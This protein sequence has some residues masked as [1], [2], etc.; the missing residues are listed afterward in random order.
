MQTDTPMGPAISQNAAKK[1]LLRAALLLV[2]LT[3]SHLSHAQVGMPWLTLDEG[4][5]AASTDQKILFVFV[6]AEWCAFCKRMK[7]EVF[8]NDAVL[9]LLRSR[10]V[11]V[12]IDV[13]SKSRVHFNGK[14]YSERSFAR[15]M[16][17]NATPT[18]IFA[19]QD[20]EI[21]GQ[22]SGFYDTDRFLLLLNY[23]DSDSFK[24]IS[25]DVFEKQRKSVSAARNDRPE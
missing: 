8:P 13:D 22:T 17:V 25:F 14:T 16:G 12:S 15:E 23:L 9:N 24:D 21:L 20:G 4:Q 7:R 6:E 19:N 10:F 1:S 18:I 3:G 2:L 11:P 5:I